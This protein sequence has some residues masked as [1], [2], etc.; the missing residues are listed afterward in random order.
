MCLLSQSAHATRTELPSY[1]D[2]LLASLQDGPNHFL[3]A[4][5]TV[6]LQLRGSSLYRMSLARGQSPR[7]KPDGDEGQAWGC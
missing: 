2:S 5:N 4:V 3:W 6:T 1:E 7:Q